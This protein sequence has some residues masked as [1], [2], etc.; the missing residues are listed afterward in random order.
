VLGNR[1]V[2]TNKPFIESLNLRNTPFDPQAMRAAYEPHAM[3]T[4]TYEWTLNPFVLD[5]FVPMGAAEEVN[6]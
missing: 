5:R 2:L 6:A 1:E 4:E 3:S